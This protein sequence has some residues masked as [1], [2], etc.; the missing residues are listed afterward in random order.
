MHDA[1]DSVDKVLHNA[2]SLLSYHAQKFPALIFMP[3]FAQLK[4]REKVLL[5]S[6]VVGNDHKFAR[7]LYISAILELHNAIEYMTSS[8]RETL[9]GLFK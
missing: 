6:I 3:E 2:V 9:K 5:Y 4:E 1:N 7:E 8:E